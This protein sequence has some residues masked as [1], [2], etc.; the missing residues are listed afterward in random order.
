[1]QVL[2]EVAGGL[3]FYNARYYDPALGRFVSADTLIP[4][5]GNPQNL[6]RYSYA[7]NNP[8]VFVDPSGYAPQDPNDSDDNPA[9]C[10][11]DWC[12]QNRWHRA[13]G[14]SW[15][16]SGW[17]LA[18]ADARFYDM[19]ILDDTMD[20]LGITFT[21]DTRTPWTLSQASL[22]AQGVVA[23]ANK[24]GS[25]GQLRS[26][27]GFGVLPTVFHRAAVPLWG[28]RNTPA[29]TI[30]GT[31]LVVF[32]NDLFGGSDDFVRGTAVH[33]LAHVIDYF[34]GVG[35][36]PCS[37]SSLSGCGSQWRPGAAVPKGTHISDYAVH[38]RLG[39][40]YWAEAVAIWVYGS[41]YSTQIAGGG[42]LSPNQ[43][44]WIERVLKGWGW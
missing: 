42:A 18:G 14:Y 26:L 19:N 32:T 35:Y 6:N 1:G 29:H 23:L 41:R 17:Q 15:N 13:H 16:G 28:V 37:S 4:N 2:D 21:Q 22:V 24:I 11:T 27:L 33:E 3:Y 39:L 44:D 40:E 31:T 36:M 10:A 8:T 12:W 30:P 38:N 5:A 7:L 25:F 34:N 9:P 43:N 20:E